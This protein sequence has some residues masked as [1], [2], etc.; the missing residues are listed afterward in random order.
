MSM[1]ICGPSRI[2]GAA[3][4]LVASKVG[5]TSF[6]SVCRWRLARV[7]F[8]HGGFFRRG[9]LIGS[10]APLACGQSSRQTPAGLAIVRP[11]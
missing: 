10:V 3:R 11:K 9:R 8:P 6:C 5:P 2:G 1:A 4:T 7:V